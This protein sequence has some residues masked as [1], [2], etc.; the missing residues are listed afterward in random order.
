MLAGEPHNPKPAGSPSS[1]KVTA[2][3]L[4]GEPYN[5]K[6][7]AI[8]TSGMPAFQPS[9]CEPTESGNVAVQVEA[10]K[11]VVETSRRPLE[12]V[13]IHLKVFQVSQIYIRKVSSEQRTGA[14]SLSLL[15]SVQPAA[16]VSAGRS[17]RPKSNA[18]TQ[19]TTT[20]TT[21][22]TNSGTLPV[23]DMPATATRVQGG[24]TDSL[25]NHQSTIEV[26]ASVGTIPSDGIGLSTDRDARWYVPATAGVPMRQEE[27]GDYG[28]YFPLDFGIDSGNVVYYYAKSGPVE[29]PVPPMSLCRK[30]FKLH[31][32]KPN[33]NLVPAPTTDNIIDTER[34]MADSPAL[35]P[36]LSLISDPESFSSL[37]LPSID[38]RRARLR[39]MSRGMLQHQQTLTGYDLIE[40]VPQE[41]GPSPHADID[42]ILHKIFMVPKKQP[43]L[44]RI[45]GDLEPNCCVCVQQKRPW[46]P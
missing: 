30:R 44:G 45:I 46:C 19:I 10:E 23:D 17:I 14:T 29:K 1:M 42:E 18:D 26:A 7:T 22:Q 2:P 15:S 43:T 3:M 6:S 21:T 32:T 13:N 24:T 16:P 39:P 34:L 27:E 11:C 37:F 40:P 8:T 5:P 9:T 33:N 4:A 38:A 41:P 35:R 36:L 28:E 12:F 20:T 31:T 25:N